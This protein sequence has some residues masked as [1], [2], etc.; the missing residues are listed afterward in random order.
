MEP[1]SVE[2]VGEGSAIGVFERRVRS[3]WFRNAIL[4][5]L[6]NPRVERNPKVPH[7]DSLVGIGR[8]IGFAIGFPMMG[9]LFVGRVGEGL[10]IGLL[11]PS[12][13]VCPHPTSLAATSHTQVSNSL[14]S[15]FSPE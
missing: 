11:A 14:R 15:P 4:A 5:S 6:S 2:R 13:L 12:P 8:G 7:P 3:I 9:A 10:A 1:L